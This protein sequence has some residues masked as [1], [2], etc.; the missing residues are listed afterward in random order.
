MKALQ[1]VDGHN[2]NMLLN[3]GKVNASPSPPAHIL[4]LGLS[5]PFI[6]PDICLSAIQ[7]VWMRKTEI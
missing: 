4:L 3:D 7:V 1:D 6:P 2:V 5:D